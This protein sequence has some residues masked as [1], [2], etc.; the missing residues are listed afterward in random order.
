MVSPRYDQIAALVLIVAVGLGMIF[1]IDINPHILLAR[2][3]DSLPAI[4][5]TWLLVGLL[6]LIASAGADALIRGVPAIQQRD[7]PGMTL[8]G[9]CFE[10]A[11]SFWILPFFSVVG[12]YAFF[13][14]FN[15]SLQGLALVLALLTACGL[16]LGVLIG[17]HYALLGLRTI[18][19]QAQL[20]LQVITL[21]LAFACFSVVL[22]PQFR[23]L[24][25]APLIALIGV[26]LSIAVLHWHTSE[27]LPVLAAAIGVVLAEATWALNYWG[28]SFLI[29]AAV[30]LLLFYVIVS[31]LQQFYSQ[32]LRPN[33]AVEYGL[34]GGGLLAVLI[35]AVLR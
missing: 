6:G 18:S 7:L 33:I 16:L 32:G 11:P 2:F 34:V 25:A 26:L 24:I 23:S 9:K 31:M 17:Q 3:G 12:A 29:A 4:S 35:F 15:V 1:L 20:G 30:L 28:T 5:V 8:F 13:R 22:L 21:L 10:I 19:A 14:V 27:G